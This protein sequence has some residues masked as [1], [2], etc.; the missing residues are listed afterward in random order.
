M[1]TLELG[2]VWYFFYII[3]SA[4]VIVAGYF[5]FRKA[6]DKA[7]FYYV[8]ALSFIN[9]AVHFL[10]MLL[11]EYQADYP[12]SWRKCTFEN[13]C[14]VSV[15]IYPF[16]LLSKSDTAKDYV[17][18]LGMIGGAAA[19]FVPTGAWGYAPF[20]L[21]SIRFYLSHVLLFMQ[22]FYTLV[23]GVHRPHYKR[24]WRAPISLFIVLGVI[25]LNELVLRAAGFTVSTLEDMIADP[26]ERN[27]VYIFGLT[28]EMEG[29]LGFLTAL[30]PEFMKH[31]FGYRTGDYYWPW[32]WLFCPLMVYGEILAHA[33]G[34]IWG[35]KDLKNDIEM[36]KAASGG[37]K[38][39]RL[40]K[41][42]AK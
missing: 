37:T 29:K 4:A 11:P 22:A 19:I 24:F 31:G 21:E 16:V 14:A 17:V 6:S 3:V 12:M 39:Y 2:N 7:K 41:R 35:W 33:I 28:A 32:V 25:A 36:K 1:G 18:F 10:K 27:S 42:R 5:P 23:Y 8:L 13:I 26:S 15:L 34:F 38:N 30:V 9:L 20:R 40:R